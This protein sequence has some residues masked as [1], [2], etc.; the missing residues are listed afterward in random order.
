MRDEIDNMSAAVAKIALHHP[1]AFL[2]VFADPS[3][4]ANTFVL[5]GLAYID[6]PRATHRLAIATGAE[7]WNARMHAAIGLG[8]RETPEAT[9]ALVSLLDDE[10][11]LVRIHALKGTVANARRGD[12]VAI[13]A[14]ER[15]Q[16]RSAYESELVLTA[17]ERGPH[18]GG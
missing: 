3:L 8:N 14:L 15:Y 18:E 17:L 4:D 6:D 2:D 9:R 13:H 7:T 1:S 12:Q 5:T 16:S 11:D 10:D